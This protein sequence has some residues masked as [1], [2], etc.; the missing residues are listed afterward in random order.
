[1]I[2]GLDWV[3]CGTPDA[4]TQYASQMATP[5]EALPFWTPVAREELLRTGATYRGVITYMELWDRVQEVTG[6]RTNVPMRHAVGKLLA[7]V[8]EFSHKQGDP[9]ITSLC[10]HQDGTI[11]PG[12][13]EALRMNGHDEPADLELRAA[14]D[15]LSCYRALASDLPVDGGRP[16]FT[17]QVARKRDNAQR[18]TKPQAEGVLC[19]TCFMQ[20]SLTGACGTCD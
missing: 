1:M 2:S 19:P 7:S 6:I 15:R 14:E 20:M 10:V 3:E 5:T 4:I 13:V 9:P 16:Y 11:G 12:Y 17:E 8:V 18:N